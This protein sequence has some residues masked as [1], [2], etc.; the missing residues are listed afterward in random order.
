MDALLAIS[1]TTLLYAFLGGFL[2]VMLWFY[3]LLKEDYV[4]P[5]PRTM[6]GL[7]FIA[8]MASVPLAAVFSVLFR[9]YAYTVFATCSPYLPLCSPIILGWAAIEE[10]LKYLLVALLVLWRRCVD[11]AIDLVIYMVTA[12][13]GF[14]ALENMLFLLEPFSN[15]DYLAALATGNLRFVGSTVLHVIASASIGFWLAFSVRFPFSIRAV[16]AALGLIHAIALHAIFN[17]LIIPRDES[18]TILTAFLF[19]WGC[20]VSCFAMFEVVKY[21]QRRRALRASSI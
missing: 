9:E 8:G 3:V 14:A 20:A 11:E 15:G 21:L 16:G 12:A 17:F 18:H 4:N 10:T 19:V 2:P 1:S 6:L 7:A 5:E 13:L